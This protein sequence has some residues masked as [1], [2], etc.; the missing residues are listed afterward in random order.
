[1]SCSRT[2]HSR[3][4]PLAPESDALPLSHHSP[5][6]TYDFMEKLKK[7]PKL[8]SSTLLIMKYLSI[9]FSFCCLTRYFRRFWFGLMLNIPVNNF[10]VMLGRSHRFLGITSTFG[11]LI[12]LA[13]GHNMATR[14]GLEPQTSGSGVRGV[15]HQATA[16]PD[17]SEGR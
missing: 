10:S 1:M 8:S 14:M 3:G 6:T 7:I 17:I 2:Q 13:Q 5:F 16:P 12:C 11:G 15:N 4:R 9:F